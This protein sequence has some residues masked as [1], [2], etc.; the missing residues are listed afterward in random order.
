MNVVRDVLSSLMLVLR[1]RGLGA[2]IEGHLCKRK[3]IFSNKEGL[4][5]IRNCAVDKSSMGM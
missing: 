4:F 2:G 3:E 5:C 1:S